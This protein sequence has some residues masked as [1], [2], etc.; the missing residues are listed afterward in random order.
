ML[1]KST[2]TC[3]IGTVEFEQKLDPWVLNDIQYFLRLFIYA[4]MQSSLYLTIY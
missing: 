3:F 2:V 1:L 4:H